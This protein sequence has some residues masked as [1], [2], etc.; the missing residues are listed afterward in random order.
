MLTI[1]SHCLT[2]GGLRRDGQRICRRTGAGAAMVI[3][4]IVA[5]RTIRQANPPAEKPSDFIS[6]PKDARCLAIQAASP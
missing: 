4:P 5:Y 3:R 6:I 2:I 1:D